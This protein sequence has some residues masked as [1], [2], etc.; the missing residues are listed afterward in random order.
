MPPTQPR[1][2]ADTAYQ[3]INRHAWWSRFAGYF[4]WTLFLV[5]LF[6]APNLAVVPDGVARSYFSWL[7]TFAT[8]ALAFD[9]VVRLLRWPVQSYS[10]CWKH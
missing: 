8:I 7:D 2:K 1:V 10:C 4:W 3:M 6:L 9:V 5:T